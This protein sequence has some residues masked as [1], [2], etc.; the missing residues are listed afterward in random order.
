MLGGVGEGKGTGDLAELEV[1]DGWGLECGVG[2]VVEGEARARLER[3]CLGPAAHMMS[4]SRL[5]LATQSSARGS[6]AAMIMHMKGRPVRR[7]VG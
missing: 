1:R 5:A 2:W 4:S 6:E 3:A 7:S